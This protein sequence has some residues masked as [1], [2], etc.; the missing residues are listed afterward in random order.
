[1]ASTSVFP[2]GLPNYALAAARAPNYVNASDLGIS[3]AVTL[4]IP[5]G[6]QVVE[7]KAN[8]DFYVCW[9]ST[10]VSTGTASAGTASELIPVQSGGVRRNIGSSL[11]TTAISVMS[12]AACHLTQVWWTY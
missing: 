12:T 9:G 2:T 5:A 1:M 11:G 8:F 6:V 7:L 10:G 4:T 3:S